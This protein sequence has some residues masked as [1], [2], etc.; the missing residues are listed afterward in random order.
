MHDIPSWKQELNK[1]L[2]AIRE[3]VGGSFK[4]SCPAT[5]ATGNIRREGVA[6]KGAARR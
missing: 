3:R 6:G 4:P 1:R 2:A 5:T